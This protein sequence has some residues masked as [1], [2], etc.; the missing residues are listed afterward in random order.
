MGKRRVARERAVQFLF[1]YELNPPEEIETAIELFWETQRLAGLEREHHQARWGEPLAIP[2]PTTEEAGIR[3]FADALIR[4]ILTHW[5]TIDAEI[6]KYA[7]NW[8]LERMAVV[9]RNVIRLATYEMLYRPDIPPIVSINEA[10]DIAKKY[11]TQDSGRF[12]NGVLDQIRSELLRPART[13]S[14]AK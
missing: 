7:Q 9:D 8:N 12:V 1:Q 6:K 5:A 13:A 3:V 10:V 4:G 2:P 11:S 14:D